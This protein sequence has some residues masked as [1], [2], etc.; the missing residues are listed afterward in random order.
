MIKYKLI[1][2]P[3]L[4]DSNGHETW[5]YNWTECMY[6]LG[7]LIRT[8][9]VKNTDY[10]EAIE[11]FSPKYRKSMRK[12]APT[13]LRENWNTITYTRK[14]ITLNQQTNEKFN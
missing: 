11:I 2:S 6:L 3:S 4:R 8:I 9:Q 5:T 7:L 10:R 12:H 14:Q 13:N 1:R